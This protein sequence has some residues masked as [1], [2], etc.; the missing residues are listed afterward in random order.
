MEKRR[1]AAEEA[2]LNRQK[3]KDA[4]ASED[5]DNTAVLDTLLDKLRNGDNIGRKARR[6][7]PS[8]S[9]RPA[10][11]LDLVAASML[12]PGTGN[13]TV[14]LARDMLARLKSDGFDALPATSPTA[15]TAP[16]R[17]RRR[18]RGISEDLE[19]SPFLQGD[20]LSDG[21]EGSLDS[22]PETPNE[23]LEEIEADAEEPL[24]AAKPVP[25]PPEGDDA[26]EGDKDKTEV[27]DA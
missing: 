22:L 12:A 20:V 6:A 14:D 16:R 21:P 10:A 4:A 19:G 7:R 5:A 9:S 25:V 24:G 23:D 8:T 17:S 3:A 27:Q 18:V 1:Q 15:P 13:D 11:P 26:N 2:K